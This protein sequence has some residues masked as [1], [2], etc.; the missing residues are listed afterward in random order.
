MLQGADTVAELTGRLGDRELLVVL[1]N[2]EQLAGDGADVLLQVLQQNPRVRLLLT[3]RVV[4]GLREEWL[5]S[6]TGLSLEADEQG[7]SD[8]V[9]L[10][11]DRARQ[12]GA[13]I[14]PSDKVAVGVIARIAKMV[15]GMPL[16]LELAAAH[17]R[18]MP[19][20]AIATHLGRDL[21]VL[22]VDIRNIPARHQSIPGLLEESYRYLS[23]EQ[24]RGL[25]SL[26]VFEGS[27]SAA[28]AA[29]VADAPLRV[30]AALVDQ[31]LVQPREGRFSLHPLLRQFARERLGGS[32]TELQE[33][34]A[35][36]FCELVAAR[37]DALEQRYQVE[38]SLELDPEIENIIAGWRW[39]ASE[40]RADLLSAAAYP[41]GLYM[42]YRS[43][44]IEASELYELA[45]PVLEAG[46]ETYQ[47][48]LASMLTQLGWAYLRSG[49][50]GLAP[51]VLRRA[52]EI[53]DRCDAGPGQGIGRDPVTAEALIAW[54][55]GDYAV[56]EALS[57]E[58]SRSAHLREDPLGEALALFFAGSLLLRQ[59]EL[60]WLEPDGN[61]SGDYIPAPSSSGAIDEAKRRLDGAASILEDHGEKWLRA[62]VEIARAGHIPGTR[63]E[64]AVRFERAAILAKEFGNASGRASTLVSFA[65]FLVDSSDVERAEE[66][67]AEARRLH[68]HLGDP[69]GIAEVER[70]S[71]R[72][73]VAA[74]DFA[75]AIGHA[76]AS[77][78]LSVRLRFANNVPANFFI[79]ADVLAAIGQLA[80]AAELYRYIAAH[81]VTT[82]F[83]RAKARF[84]LAAIREI[85]GDA[86]GLSRPWSD[87]A[88][89]ELY[90][91]ASIVRKRMESLLTE[92]ATPPEAP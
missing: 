63:A 66:A 12:A 53:F 92:L 1:D 75:G 49:R 8:A 36:Y 55:A 9:R 81:P 78:D 46:G 27:F 52:R 3:S 20:E 28:A 44:L 77:L 47:L 7:L 58:A 50:G 56:A 59:A 83:S 42:Q 65:D 26:S 24:M 57:L 14:D 85:P 30:L 82:A 11:L 6:A 62:L 70:C 68:A 21:D 33:R 15:D 25:L 34:H 61:G 67:L 79:T 41:L 64:K 13:S 23:V 48:D 29:E 38:T 43:R 19:V 17:T 40:H 60:V 87:L 35:R 45:V 31:S 90:E 18:F 39:A 51:A 74:G 5:F 84:K 89:L 54:S 69:T 10:F 91:A 16:A 71:G 37:C 86:G 80:D 32:F 88:G 4:L 22:Q 72:A 76:R 2:F 73:R